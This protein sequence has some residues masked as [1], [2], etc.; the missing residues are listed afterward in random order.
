[1]VIG[2]D[3]I[4]SCKTNYHTVTIFPTLLGQIC[5]LNNAKIE[6]STET[7]YFEDDPVEQSTVAS[8]G[9]PT[10]HNATPVPSTG[11]ISFSFVVMT[12]PFPPPNA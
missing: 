2:T 5:Y 9:T 12:S 4:G 10:R 1:V 6:T 7:D 3:C 11:N 8:S